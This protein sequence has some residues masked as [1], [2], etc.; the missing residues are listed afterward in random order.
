MSVSQIIFGLIHG[1]VPFRAVLYLMGFLSLLRT[2]KEK[3]NSF[4]FVRKNR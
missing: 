4:E 1:A 2:K 3:K